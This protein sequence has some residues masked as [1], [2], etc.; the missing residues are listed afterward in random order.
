MTVAKDFAKLWQY[1]IIQALFAFLLAAARPAGFCGPTL[2]CIVDRPIPETSMTK[3]ELIALLRECAQT[4]KRNP[5][6]EDLRR[7]P[8]FRDRK[9]YQHFDRLGEALQAAGLQPKGSG[10]KIPTVDLM[11]DWAGVVRRLKSI[12]TANQYERQGRFNTIPLA[13]RFGGWRRVPEA[14]RRFARQHSIEAEWKDVLEMIA[15]REIAANPALRRGSANAGPP[16]RAGRPVYGDPLMLPG[17]AREPV[18]E[19]GVIF[20]FGA[21]AHRLGF[22]VE[23]IQP[24]FPDCEALHE[25]SPGRWQR[26]RIEF[27]YTSRNF[28][29]HRHRHQEC[30]AIVCWLHDWTDCPEGLHVIELKRIV[31]NL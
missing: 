14:F 8:G 27:E 24:G 29:R 11:L 4:L 12:P 3:D 5:T 9:L 20:L 7:T 19:F 26:L 1:R 31:R 25:V 15:A 23:R 28:A 30:D 17:L 16:L 10:Y 22:V 13:K 6:F 18:N 21:V 2:S